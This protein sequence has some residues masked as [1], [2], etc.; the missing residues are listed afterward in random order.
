M[1]THKHTYRERERESERQRDREREKQ[2]S[3]LLVHSPNAHNSQGWVRSKL[4]VG[5]SIQV[6]HVSGRDPSG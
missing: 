4:G 6:S 5:N 3:R 2:S 1:H